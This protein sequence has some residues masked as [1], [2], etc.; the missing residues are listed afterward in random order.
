MLPFRFWR[1]RKNWGLLASRS[2]RHLLLAIRTQV[3]LNFVQ[4]RLFLRVFQLCLHPRILFLR[5]R[6]SHILTDLF[7]E[8]NGVAFSDLPVLHGTE[9]LDDVEKRL[10]ADKRVFIVAVHQRGDNF[11]F[12]DFVAKRR[13]LYFALLFDE[14]LQFMKS[15]FEDSP[16][17]V[18]WVLSLRP[19]N[20]HIVAG[21][22]LSEGFEVVTLQAKGF[23]QYFS[24][25]DQ[26]WLTSIGF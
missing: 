22:L 15:T 5:L 1:R 13:H 10:T 26:L 8:L 16:D 20:V 6:F 14:L 25:S 24:S 12:L 3:K 11:L 18:I 19:I 4:N 2:R 21:K 23:H 9:P 17:E 7:V